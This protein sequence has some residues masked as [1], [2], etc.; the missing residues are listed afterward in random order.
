[1]LSLLWLT[2]KRRSCAPDG[3][4]A[5]FWLFAAF[6]AM[7]PGMAVAISAFASSLLVLMIDV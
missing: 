6:C 4:S 7:S 3:C 2:L 5:G 1:M